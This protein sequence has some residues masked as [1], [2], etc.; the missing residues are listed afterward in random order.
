MGDRN[1]FKPLLDYKNF[2]FQN[3]SVLYMYSNPFDQWSCN[4]NKNIS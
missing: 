4:V 3:T 2:I 1:N